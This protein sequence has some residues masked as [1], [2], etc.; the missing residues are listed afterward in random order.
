VCDTLI[1]SLPVLCICF[2]D[3]KTPFHEAVYNGHVDVM[4]YLVELGAN[5]D[6]K[7]NVSCYMHPCIVFVST[8]RGGVRVRS[9]N[10]ITSCSMHFVFSMH[11]LLEWHDPFSLRCYATTSGCHE[12]SGGAWCQI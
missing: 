6:E 8:C 3:G 7:G 1:S 12:I 2:Q 11:L 9:P 10:F 4:K 5:Y